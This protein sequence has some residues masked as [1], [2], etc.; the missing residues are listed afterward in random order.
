MNR[1]IP[2]ATV[3]LMAL[4]HLVAGLT[5]ASAA[6]II[7][8]DMDPGTSGI[9]T[10]LMVGIGDIFT[11]DVLIEDDGA[12]VTP[13]V[14]DTII[15]EAFFNDAGIVLGS[16]PTGPIAGTLAATTGTLD[17]YGGLTSIDLDDSITTGT[18]YPEAPF[19]SG[20]GALGLY[21]PAAFTISPGSPISVFSIDFT[22]LTPGS[23]T[24]SA[25]GTPPSSAALA[26]AGSPVSA[27]TATGSITVNPE[28]SSA[29]IFG[30]LLGGCCFWMRR[31]R[32]IVSKVS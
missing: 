11:V 5:A 24:I 6:P 32:H 15:L 3:T 7:S 28:P 4:Y 22:A 16:G 21:N 8:V 14:F 23:S 2:S 9:Q 10:T 18:S 25:T 19:A 1:I 27:A 20:S 30:V 13:T 26:F 31:Q 12:W 17:L 29:A